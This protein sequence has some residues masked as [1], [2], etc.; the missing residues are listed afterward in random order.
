MT[1]QIG[2]LFGEAG[3]D[4]VVADGLSVMIIV[5]AAASLVAYHMLMSRT[6][7]WLR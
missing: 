6:A 5:L 7:R 3:Y 2:F 4:L 1:I